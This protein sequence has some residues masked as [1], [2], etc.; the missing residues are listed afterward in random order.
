MNNATIAVDILLG[1]GDRDGAFTLE[2]LLAVSRL[3]YE[4]G[5]AD[6]QIE[7]ANEAAKALS[8]V[9]CF[10]MRWRMR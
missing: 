3:A 10:R 8:G 7:I 6:G 4:I 2:D 5:R 1:D 9:G